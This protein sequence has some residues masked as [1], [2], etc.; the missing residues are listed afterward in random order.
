MI[1]R[2]RMPT[3][4]FWFALPPICGAIEPAS[5]RS[6]FLHEQFHG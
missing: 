4:V 1:D 3:G 2:R 6:A 5:S